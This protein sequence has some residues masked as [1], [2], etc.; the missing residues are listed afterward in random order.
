MSQMML[1]EEN[2][3]FVFFCFYH[4]H[5]TCFFCQGF[6]AIWEFR[7]VQYTQNLTAHLLVI[8]DFSSDELK[9][10]D[11]RQGFQKILLDT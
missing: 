11:H 1:N 7:S 9:F 5:K 4:I 2:S 10:R 8:K 3:F 6:D